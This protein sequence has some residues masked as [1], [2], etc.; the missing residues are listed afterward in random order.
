MGGSRSSSVAFELDPCP[1]LLPSFRV[2][3]LKGRHIV[4]VDQILQNIL[5]QHFSFC[6]ISFFRATWYV[7]G[8]QINFLFRGIGISGA[9]PLALRP[10]K[11]EVYL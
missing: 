10:K 5:S 6:E 7:E 8:A 2:Y 4:R 3:V 1:R 11:E 9:E